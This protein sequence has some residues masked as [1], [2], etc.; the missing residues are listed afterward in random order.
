MEIKYG[1]TAPDLTSDY[2]PPRE[3]NSKYLKEENSI[4]NKSRIFS[5]Q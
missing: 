5:Q 2:W 1:G 3:I 4:P